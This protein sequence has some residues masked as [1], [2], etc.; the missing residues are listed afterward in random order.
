MDNPYHYI[1]YLKRK[2]ENRGCQYEQVSDSFFEKRCV[3]SF[4]RQLTNFHLMKK[5]N[6]SDIIF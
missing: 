6:R 2:Y 4:I 5:I 3:K 1:S